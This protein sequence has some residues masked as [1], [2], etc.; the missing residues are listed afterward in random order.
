METNTD[1][2]AIIHIRR[3]RKNR[4]AV[5]LALAREQ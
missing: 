5:V 1:G 4:E 2:N 3:V